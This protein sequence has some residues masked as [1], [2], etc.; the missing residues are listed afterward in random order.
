[1]DPK[2]LKI[3]FIGIAPYPETAFCGQKGKGLKITWDIGQVTCH[4]CW[5]KIKS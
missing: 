4:R 1:M 5:K 3:H 2:R